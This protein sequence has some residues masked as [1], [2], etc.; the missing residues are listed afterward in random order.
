[1]PT[2]HQWPEQL[3][4]APGTKQLKSF[5]TSFSARD[6]FWK[7]TSSNTTTTKVTSANSLSLE[8][9]WPNLVLLLRCTI[10]IKH[11][12]DT[13]RVRSKHI[14]EENRISPL[15]S[16]LSFPSFPSSYLINF[17]GGTR[18][19]TTVFQKKPM[20]KQTTYLPPELSPPSGFFFEVHVNM[21]CRAENAQH[22]TLW[23]IYKEHVGKEQIK[24]FWQGNI[25]WGT[26]ALD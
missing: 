13:G 26:M 15:N 16:T 17:L 1:M 20:E 8:E 7:T 5:G 2:N 24:Q 9:G 6:L 21:A 11:L 3:G 4:P 18:S 25:L 14:N 19:C 10:S 12:E 22:L 23:A